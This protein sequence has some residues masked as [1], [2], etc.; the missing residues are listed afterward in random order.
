MSVKVTSIG[1]KGLDGYRVQGEDQVKEGIES[2][3]I[4]GLPDASVKES[5]ERVAA[6]LHS[7]GNSLVDMKVT[8]NL[9]PAEQKKN[10]PLFDLAIAI[11]VLISGKFVKEKIPNDTGFIGAIS[12]D[13]TILP[14]EGMIAAILAAKKLKLNKL[15][16]PFD[17]TI[18]KIELTD[19]ELVYI[20]TIQDV[21]DHLAGRPML[22]LLQPIDLLEDH[23][24]VERDFNQIIGHEF[25]KRALEIAASGEHYVLMD[26]PPG[27][28]KS[29]LAETFPSILPSLSKEAQLEKISLYQLAGAPYHSLS[30]PSYRHPHHSAS[31]V[32]IIGGGTNPKPGEVS[33]AHRGVLFLDEL[34]EFSK[35]TLDML[36]QPLENEKVTISRVH[37]TVTY[38]AKFIFIAAMNPCPCGYFGSSQQYC[39]CSEN[40]IK[41]YQNRVSGPIL[42]RI[43]ILLSLKPVNLK[44][45]DFKGIESSD[46]AQK[47]VI[48]ARETQYKRYGKEICNGS[49]PFEK[50]I[51]ESPLTS[52]QQQFLQCMSIKQGLS[53]RVQIKI[54]RLARTIADL[55][56]E[57]SISDEALREAIQLRKID[58]PKEM[59]P[60]E[61]KAGEKSEWN[62]Q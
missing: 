29:L 51:G 25:A 31:S 24:V 47:R 11:G 53:N 41:S 1:L 44:D 61:T 42:D 20:E 36:R 40:K 28:G 17:P 49:V 21:M 2:I 27:C 45:H 50:L 18:P 8:I 37:S 4:V 10:G 22:P 56:G 14:V 9:S 30:L 19:L 35:K 13:G 48:A 6:A 58:K 43:D 39:T 12:L 52:R 32:S 62:Y 54:I 23:M 57:K 3:V 33:L 60:R 15:F 55:N 7:M 38:P 26:G 5:K 46:E 16:L 59:A 34:G